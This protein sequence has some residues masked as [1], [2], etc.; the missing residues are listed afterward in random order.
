MMQR[1]GKT[2]P[3]QKP[4]RAK[5]VRMGLPVDPTDD[6]KNGKPSRR[7]GDKLSAHRKTSGHPLTV[8]G[9]KT[10]RQPDACG[11][12]HGGHAAQRGHHGSSGEPE[13]HE[14][15]YDGRRRVDKYASWSIRATKVATSFLE[16]PSI[17]MPDHGFVN[18]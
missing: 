15:S 3:C 11:L 2:A 4:V 14:F 7:T 9:I 8:P 16:K 17:G 18:L 10:I 13:S 6:P 12:W 1:R 5:T